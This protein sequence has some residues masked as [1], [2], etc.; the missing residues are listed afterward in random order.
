MYILSVDF[1]TSS[2]KVAILDE[3]NKI[4]DSASAEYNYTVT[5]KDWVVIETEALYLG[6]IE[7]IQDLKEYLPKVKIIAYDTFSPSMT[8]MDENGDALYPTIT[9]LDRRAKKQSKDI[10]E[11]MGEHHFQSITGILP[12]IGGAS[13]TTVMWIKENLPEIF[14]KT[15]KFAHLSTY[16]YKKLTGIW[17]TDPVN[18]S[19]T[20]MYETVLD[21]NWSKEICDQ[22]EIPMDKLPDIH[23]AGS[24]LGFLL[25][26]QAKILGLSANIPVVLGTNDAAA[27]QIGAG[28]TSPGDILNTSGSSEMVSILTNIPIVNEKYYLRKAATP[29]L[30]QIYA[31]TLGG[32]GL[33]WFRKE[34]CDDMEK[35][36]YYSKYVPEVIGKKENEIRSSFLPY[37]AGDR[38]SL[39]TKQGSFNGLTLATRREDMLLAM[40][41]S[42]NDVMAVTL[43]LARKILPLSDSVKITGGLTS[44]NGYK[45]LKEEIFNVKKIDVVKDCPILGNGIFAM[46]YLS[47]SR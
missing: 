27:A 37:M 1:G 45:E 38:Q 47:M 28:N 15:Y 18:A 21:R 35:D 6:F 9:H 33:E 32:F 42:T 13:I 36:E 39:E 19:M 5:N 12:F 7:A 25:P 43:N 34:I 29:G 30:W 2:V 3:Q 22:F 16:F 24:V 17:A 4:V 23:P 14:S 26:D 10:C 46:N 44:I 20:G 41:Y 11:V 31:T 8:F 40:L